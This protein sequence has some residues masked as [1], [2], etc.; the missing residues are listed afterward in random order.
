[1]PNLVRVNHWT[2]LK[3]GSW[4]VQHLRERTRRQAAWRHGSYR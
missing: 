2:Q 1:M 3:M 4:Y